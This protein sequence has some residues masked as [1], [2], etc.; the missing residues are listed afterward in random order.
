MKVLF[1]CN[2]NLN[3]SK[4]AEEIFKASF[5]TWSAG[6]YNTYPLTGSQLSWADLVVVMEDEQRSE[7]ARRFPGEYLSTRII[8]LGIPDK[9][10]YRDP[11]LIKMLRKKMIAISPIVS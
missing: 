3:R 5:E 9:Y 2:Q 11:E 7:I 1:V 4:T 10:Q 8:S 6:L